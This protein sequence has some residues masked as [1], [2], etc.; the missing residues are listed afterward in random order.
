MFLSKTTIL[1]LVDC[2]LQ[3]NG[4]YIL[5]TFTYLVSTYKYILFQYNRCL[6]YAFIFALL[7]STFRVH[8]DF[9][10]S[11]IF[12]VYLK[13][14]LFRIYCTVQTGGRA[15]CSVRYVLRHLFLLPFVHYVHN[16]TLSV[17]NYEIDFF[18][19]VVGFMTCLGN[20]RQKKRDLN[21]MNNKEY[22]PTT[23]NNL[24]HL[25]LFIRWVS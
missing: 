13:G 17:L 3:M 21:A 6:G 5:W 15:L 16:K 7:P 19:T 23:G 9:E 10:K 25:F 11:L 12:F 8:D 20:H 4:Y 1:Q 14:T 2:S 18:H 24:L 22:R